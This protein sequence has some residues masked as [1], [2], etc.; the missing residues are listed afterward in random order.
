MERGIQYPWT[1]YSCVEIFNYLDAIFLPQLSSVIAMMS[2][3]FCS[4]LFNKT[5]V[6]VFLFM[7]G[8]DPGNSWISASL[9]QSFQRIIAGWEKKGKVLLGQFFFSLFI[10]PMNG[11]FPLSL[12]LQISKSCYFPS[13]S[14]LHERTLA[15]IMLASRPH[16]SCESFPAPIVK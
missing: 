10:I 12:K 9:R 11:F 2:I 14:N 8:R 1:E 5:S 16:K 7:K 6:F 4:D 15:S 3:S 13:F